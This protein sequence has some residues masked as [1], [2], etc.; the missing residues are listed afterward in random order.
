MN[1]KRTISI[2]LILSA[3]FIAGLAAQPRPN[4]NPLL[5]RLDNLARDFESLARETGNLAAQQRP[6]QQAL[7]RAETNRRNLLAQQ[8]RNQREWRDFFSRGGDLTR[9][10]Q[11]RLN[12]ASNRILLADDRIGANIRTINSR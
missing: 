2:A 12:A 7:N 10:E 3:V 9:A 6:N 1:L 11:D 8:A 5:I 4:P